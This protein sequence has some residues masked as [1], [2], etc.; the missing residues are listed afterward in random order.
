MLR[1][2]DWNGGEAT[3]RGIARCLRL[4]AQAVPLESVRPAMEINPMLFR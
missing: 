1:Q 4:Q 3:P 2:V